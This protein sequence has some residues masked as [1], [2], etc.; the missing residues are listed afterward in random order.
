MVSMKA[1]KLTKSP[2]YK[3]CPV[4]NNTN[5]NS[6]FCLLK[7]QKLILFLYLHF[8][9]LCGS[10]HHQRILKKYPFWKCESCFPSEASK[11]TLVGKKLNLSLKYW[12]RE[13]KIVFWMCY[14]T[15]KLSKYLLETI[16]T[17]FGENN[18]YWRGNID[19]D[20]KCHAWKSIISGAFHRSKFWHISRKPA[21]I[22]SE[23]LFF[24]NCLVM[25]WAT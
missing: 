9:W 17:P 1:T 23:W 15:Q 3:V 4:E 18:N 8:T 14:G 5:L 6:I 25:P 2:P 21:V 20:R 11:F 7:G 16:Q 13:A 22:F 19:K 24:Q 12:F 10:W